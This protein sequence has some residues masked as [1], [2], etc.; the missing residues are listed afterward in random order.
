MARALASLSRKELDCF[1]RRGFF[2]RDEAFGNFAVQQALERVSSFSLRPARVG[3]FPRHDAKFRS[4]RMCFTD[5]LLI[6]ALFNQSLRPVLEQGLR[7]VF[8]AEIEIQVAQFETGGLFGEHTDAVAW[9][10]EDDNS[11]AAPKRRISATWYLNSCG[12]GELALRPLEEQPKQTKGNRESFRSLSISLSFASLTLQERCERVVITG[13]S[14]GARC[15]GSGSAGRF[16]FAA[17][18]A[19]SQSG[20]G[21][22]TNCRNGMVLLGLIFGLINNR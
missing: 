13:G 18:A 1:V 4:D 20:L 3:K 12:G 19:S 7:T 16:Q 10:D 15:S 6:K 8:Q 2:V 5:D 21:G 11:A 14:S 17:H 22:A 9:S